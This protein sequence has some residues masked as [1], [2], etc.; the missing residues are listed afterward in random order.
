MFFVPG[1]RVCCVITGA[2]HG[3]GRSIAVALARQCADHKTG[4]HFILV[5]RLGKD[6]KKREIKS[7]KFAQPLKVSLNCKLYYIRLFLYC[8]LEYTKRL[9]PM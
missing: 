4:G 6:S 7:S 1:S 9:M 3:F 5:S 8:L 2:S